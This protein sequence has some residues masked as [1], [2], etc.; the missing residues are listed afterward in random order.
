VNGADG[1]IFRIALAGDGRY[2]F[3][4]PMVKRRYVLA[5]ICYLLIPVVVIAGARVHQLI[6]PEM[7]RG[8]ANY[9]RDYRLLELTRS[10]LL[11][12]SW[13]LSAVLWFSCSYLVLKSRQRSR[14]WTWLAVF[15][16]PGFAVIAALKDR[17]PAP[18][19]LYQQLIGKLRAY[20]RVPIEIALFVAVLVLTYNFM[21]LKRD[22]MIRYESFM[23]G[24]PV[25][26]IIDQQNTMSGM[27]AVGEGMEQLYLITLVYLL[28]PIVF[29]LGGRLSTARSR[30][31]HERGTS[32]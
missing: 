31:A 2:R 21:V 7:A 10:G 8:H 3:S 14:R 24:T 4:T 26:T 5:L 17:S 15:G 20:W 32:S 9:T 23:T 1:P 12:A 22:L 6:D 29:N 11:V 30:D 16:P 13:A 25:A 19:D 28:W 18:G 27:Y